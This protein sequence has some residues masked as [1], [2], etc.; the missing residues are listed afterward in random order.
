V[1]IGQWQLEIMGFVMITDPAA[2]GGVIEAKLI[3]GIDDHSHS[4]IAKV[5][6]R[7]TAQAVWT[8]A[9]LA[10]SISSVVNRCTHR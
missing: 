3:S 4:V 9:F 8:A 2:P 10:E 6:P 7:P 5:A 1:A